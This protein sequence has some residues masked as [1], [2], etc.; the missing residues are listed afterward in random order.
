[1]SF[2]LTIYIFLA[3]AVFHVN[4]ENSAVD[5]SQ[6]WNMINSLP[7]LEGLQ[8]DTNQCVPSGW[9]TIRV[10]VSSTFDDF[11]SEREVLV[12]QVFP[13]LREWCEARSM[14]LVECD[15]RWGIPK[16]TP[17]GKI[18]ATCLGELDR[19][20][21]DTFGNPFM[22]VFLGDRAGWIPDAAE[23]PEEIV[24]VYHWINGMS[25]TGTEI[26]H[27]AYR[28]HNPNAVFCLRDPSFLLQLPEEHLP[29]YQDQGHKALFMQFLKEQVSHHFP[30]DQILHYG[31]QILNTDTTA[32]KVK[33][34]FS[35]EFSSRILEFLKNRILLTFP[36]RSEAISQKGQ[37]SWEE[38]ELAQHDLFLHQ[39]QQLFL[40]RDLELQMI[41]EFLNRHQV[42]HTMVENK[43]W[44]FPI[45]LV[46]SEPG[47]GKSSLLATCLSRVHQ[48]PHSR[49]FYHFVGCCPSSVQLS[50]IVMRLCCYLFPSGPEREDALMKLRNCYRN[51]EMKEIL[52]HA[53]QTSAKLRHMPTYIFIDAINQLSFPSDMTDLFSWLSTE[54][55]LPL[56]YK[57]II[58]CTPVPALNVPSSNCLD[59]DLLSLEA[60]QSLVVLYLSRYCKI[61][62]TEQLHELLQKSSSTN[63]LWISL[64]CEEL[65]VYGVFET[66]T[67]KIIEL[68]DS[69]QGL[70]KS[71]IQRLVL[72]DDNNRVKKLVC[73]LHCCQ[74]GVAEQDL[75]GAMSTLEGVS[76]IPTMHWASL[77]RTLSCLLRV[78]RDHKGRDMLNFFHG[79]V[80]KAVDQCLHTPD[81]SRHIY[82]S[83]LADYYEYK[84]TDH[85]TVVYQLPRLLQEATMNSRLVNFLRKDRRARSIQAHTRAQYLKGVRCTN[86]CRD[87]FLRS[88]AMICGM[89]SMKTGAFGQTF[90]NSQSCVLCGMHVTIMG[91]EAF[92]CPRHH[93]VGTTECLICKSLNLRHPP[94]S[95]A[96]LC[97]MCGFHETCVALK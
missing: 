1:M 88:Q 86:V 63:P 51:E 29:K 13:E 25:V 7:P 30:E 12:K 80:A 81:N 64:A 66:L 18:F 38:S 39:K 72:E 10:F 15:L 82:L 49:I 65:R 91:K 61:L 23:V 59:L 74:E 68:P 78:G 24:D 69:L 94:P 40:G 8:H 37:M 35:S 95:P 27:G 97:H 93:R 60:A 62:S 48:I 52:Q 76:E 45:Y 46:V 21:Q 85:A 75:Q 43:D 89:C 92:L 90:L 73:L 87:G 6:M 58:S 36:E 56:S 3:V 33:L 79:T 55:F 20:R 28:N 14:W 83:S 71:I 53:L 96:L 44:S 47:R 70:L 32:G 11:H 31:C 57:C 9:I 17:S 19:C 42:D 22:V 84:C 16:D 34:G 26:M 67:K 50:N 2:L 54:G 5:L 4:N 77:R 41:L